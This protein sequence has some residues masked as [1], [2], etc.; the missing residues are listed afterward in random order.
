MI[1]A[2]SSTLPDSKNSFTSSWSLFF[3]S[4]THSS[5]DKI[6]ASHLWPLASIISGIRSRTSLLYVFII[7]MLV[8]VRI[9][10]AKCGLVYRLLFDKSAGAMH[11]FVC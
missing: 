8:L 6:R 10:A 1:S 4:I 5:S 3:H 2:N 7:R 11:F 9:A